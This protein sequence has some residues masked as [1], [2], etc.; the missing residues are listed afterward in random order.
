MR[1]SVLSDVPA[2]TRRSSRA[3][4]PSIA[5]M[6]SEETAVLESDRKLA[7][8]PSA[9][10]NV[11]PPSRNADSELSLSQEMQRNARRAASTM[12]QRLR[13]RSRTLAS[14]S[15]NSEALISATTDGSSQ[16]SAHAAP[17]AVRVDSV[18]IAA[19]VNLRSYDKDARS[20]Q[21]FIY[22]AT[23]LSACARDADG[24]LNPQPVSAATIS[25]CLSRYRKRTDPTRPLHGCASCGA[26]LLNS[27]ADLAPVPLPQLSLLKL[28]AD[29]RVFGSVLSVR[30]I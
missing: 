7:S 12:Q 16:S 3:K 5:M 1:D 8:R 17:P 20:A 30:A 19:A 25:D 22:D 14:T 10:R 21:A 18:P 26:F 2:A 11:F 27:D 29:V 13:K 23:G 28:S 9:P 24:V 4:R 15:P 6:E